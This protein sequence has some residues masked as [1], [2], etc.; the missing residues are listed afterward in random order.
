MMHCF[1]ANNNNS[2]KFIVLPEKSLEKWPQ[3]N[4]QSVKNFD[5]IISR[6]THTPDNLPSPPP[7]R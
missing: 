7:L 6:Q 3:Q 2:K 4:A 5:V 1:M